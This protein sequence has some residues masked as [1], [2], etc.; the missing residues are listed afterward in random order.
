MALYE[1]EFS[2]FP[3]KLIELH[4]FKNV[5][6]DEAAL[7]NQ[8]DTLRAKGDYDSAQAFIEGNAELLKQLIADAVTFRT[9]EE[10]IY[11]AQVYA[12]QV[13]QYIYFG[14]TVPLCSN[15]DVWIT[16]GAEGVV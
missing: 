12:K 13:R 3:D 5:G 16:G 11:N 4:H 14:D 15:D 2:Q 9:W 7:V 10:E 8:I 6:N 1:N